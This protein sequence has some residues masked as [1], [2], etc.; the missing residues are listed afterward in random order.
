MAGDWIKIETCLS[1]KPEVMQIAR[2]TGLDRWSVCGRLIDLWA[3]ADA[4]TEDGILDDVGPEVIDS[5]TGHEGFAAAMTATRPTPW[6]LVDEHGVTFTAYE[7]HNGKNA[8]KRAYDT[9]R[10]QDWRASRGI[11]PPHEAAWRH[12]K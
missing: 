1:R 6:L 4:N 3:W 10:K 5:I 11:K 2:M 12:G 9:R 7:R 8:K